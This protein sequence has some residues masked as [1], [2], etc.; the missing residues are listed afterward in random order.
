MQAVDTATAVGRT[1]LVCFYF[2]DQ[3][4]GAPITEVDETL[5]IRP[6]TRVFL[7]PQWLSGI[8]NL[9]GD[10][11]A[12]VD[13]AQLLDLPATVITDHTRI[14]LAEHE[15]RVAGILVDRMAE[16]RVVDLGAIQ[17]PPP[18][19]TEAPLLRG[20]TMV[21]DGAALRVLDLPALFESPEV[22][23]FR[24]EP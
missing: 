5:A 4:Y 6:I 20:I 21:D 14:V 22:R 15:G 9:R 7:T 17:P 23:A 8:V 12:V 18:N 13:L 1:K 3:E 16:L 2:G 11:V 19:L 10:I 24:R